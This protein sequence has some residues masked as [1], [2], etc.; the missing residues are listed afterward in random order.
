VAQIQK[1]LDAAHQADHTIQ[2]MVFE[3]VPL[4]LHLAVS[5]GKLPSS[6]LPL[7]KLELVPLLKP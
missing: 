4:V 2:T 7:K 5:D 1:Y 6:S 3:P